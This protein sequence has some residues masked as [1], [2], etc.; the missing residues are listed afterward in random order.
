L[1]HLSIDAIDN[2]IS[3]YNILE[4]MSTPSG[5]PTQEQVDPFVKPTEEQVKQWYEW[6]SRLHNNKAAQSNNKD[7]SSSR[8]N[9]FDPSDDGRSWGANNN[10]QNIETPI[11]LAAIT[12]TTEPAYKE[13]NISNLNA[14]VA[15]SGGKIVYNDGKGNPV[16]R[17]PKIQDRVIPGPPENKLA[18]RDLY[19]PISTELAIATKYPKLAGMLSDTARGILDAEE[20]NI[21]PPAFVRF[22]DAN[23]N[24]SNLDG[25]EIQQRFRVNS[26]KDIH[27]NFPPDNV[28][29]LPPG[30]GAAAFSDYAV[31]LKA[32]AL[33][34]GPNTLEFGVNAKFFQY[35][36][37]YTINV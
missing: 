15:G 18:K 9:P 23:G 30:E 37:K 28:F 36:V 26:T 1:L 33:K 5:T 8:Q 6:V 10:M 17:L 14:I 24:P 25:P 29:M 21:A 4:P 31:I 20:A 27:L 11:W 7:D 16:Q 34:P 3:R 2:L 13:S 22:L 19:I 32:D 35:S 12:A